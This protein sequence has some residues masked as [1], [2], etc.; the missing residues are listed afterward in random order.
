[1]LFDYTTVS[2]E[3]VEADTDRGLAEADALVAEAAAP[4]AQRT[5]ADTMVPL[6]RALDRVEVA[7]GRGAFMARVHADPAVRDAGQAAEERLAKWRVALSF[8]RPL[9]EAVRA[10]A[11]TSEAAALTGERRRLVDHWLRDFRRAGQE[12]GPEPRA[13]L[14][15]LRERLVELE[16]AFQRNVDEFSDGLDLTREE[17]AGLPD[18]Y[19]ERLPPGTGAETLFVSLDYPSV[20]PFL[21]QA[22]R[23]DLRELM[24]FKLFNRAAGINRPVIE[25]ALAIRARIAALFD[26][27]SWAHYA[28]EVKMA[29]DPETVRRFYDQILLPLQEKAAGELDRLARLLR[30][31][32]GDPVLRS[33]DWRYYENRVRRSEFGLDQNQVA[34]YFPLEPVVDGMLDLTGEVFGLAYRR[35]PDTHAWHPDVLLYEIHDRA[36]GDLIAH[37][38]ADLFPRDGKFGHAAAFSLVAGHLGDDGEY[39]RPVSA[40]VANFTRP[41]A[42]QPSLLRHDEVVTLFHEFGHI[43]HQSLTRTEFVRFSGTETEPD[44]V[45]APSQIME[46]WAWDPSVLRRFARHYR[47]GEPIPGDLVDQLVR[48]RDL[49][50]AVRTLRQVSLGLLDLGFHDES[51]GRDLDGVNRRA[52]SVI[53]LPFHEGT[54][55]PGGFAHLFGG[56]DAGYYGYLWSKVYGDDMF[57]RFSAEGVTNPEV[58]RAYRREILES[59]GSR[60]A[61]EMLRAFLGREPSNETFLRM[62]GI[63]P[64]P[65][66]AGASGADAAPIDAAEVEAGRPAHEAGSGR[67]E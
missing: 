27:P 51:A 52:W 59:G 41:S 48:A 35:V 55:Y 12:L 58:G 28:I 36:S 65:S 53:G 10:F 60:D 34:E 66:A 15:R 22:E 45:E 39:V 67:R 31:E 37:F 25:E 42:D 50:V 19:L 29:R 40:I 7:Y 14:E 61:E 20:F 44:F 54:F 4:R 6:D 38:Y 57:G 49:N 17:L 21:D 8:D 30:E 64:S 43:L 3:S 2:V 5:F 32:T 11:A 26:A 23:R 63:G 46:H 24:E 13:E 9:Y 47:S 33:W 56:Y 62:I 18:A 1:M 16:V